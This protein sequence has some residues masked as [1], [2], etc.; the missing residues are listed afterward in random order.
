MSI[1]ATAAPH[2]M[3]RVRGLH[4]RLHLLILAAL[5]PLLII[6]IIAIW[7]AAHESRGN[8]EQ[9]LQETA[10]ALSRGVDQG[11]EDNINQL[12]LLSLLVQQ[13]TEPTAQLQRWAQDNPEIELIGDDDPAASTLPA[14]LLQE[15]R[16]TGKVQVSN[17]FT[18]SNG[19]APEVAIVLPYRDTDGRNRILAMVQPS[20]R[21]ITTV[22]RSGGDQSLLVAVVDANGV[23]AARSRTPER[24]IGKPVPDWE[25]LQQAGGPSG[26][27]GASTKEGH[28]VVF[29]Y[30]MLQ[31]APGWALVIG[32]PQQTF[33]ARWQRPL[34]GIILGG[35]V[36][37]VIALFSANAI[38]RGILQPIRAL[39]QRGQRIADSD[40]TL[41]ELPDLP[42][43]DIR[44]VRSLQD[45]LDNTVQA[46]RRSA[47]EARA[48]A[49]DLRASKQRYRA[50]AEAGA[51]VLWESD[52]HG[53]LRSATGWRELTG[54]DDDTA[55]DQGWQDR[56]HRDDLAQIEMAQQRS[57][58]HAAPLDVEF[59]VLDLQGQWRW[60]RARG[61]PIADTND[62]WAGVLE[63][64]DARRKAQAH[65][66]YLAQHDPLTGL[67]NRT[68]LR[69]K[70][71]HALAAAHR[72]HPSALLLLDLDRFKEV[73]DTLGHPTG[74]RL[75]QE[76]AQRL[77][78]TV[79]DNDMVSRLGGD[80]FAIVMASENPM[81][82]AAATLAQRLVIALSQPF[83]LDGHQF[84]IATSIGIV[85][86]DAQAEAADT[87]M[88]NADLALYRAKDEGRA[89]YRFFETEMDTRMQRRRQ[90]E[91]ELRSALQHQQFELHYQPL[92]D[93]QLRCV[94]GFEALLRWNH[95]Q[96]G[97]LK[98]GEFLALAETLGLM[99][100]LG[101]WVLQQALSDAQAW[102]GTLKVA[103][104]L[105]VSQ[106]AQPDLA[107]NVEHALATAGLPAAR[108]ELEITENAMITNIHAASAQ[109]QRLQTAG[110]SIV[111]DDF[112]S[113]YSSLGYLQAFPFD[114]IKIDKSFVDDLGKQK[115]GSAIIGAVSH[116]CAKLDITATVEGVET[117]AQLAQLQ[118]QDC[119]EGQGFVFGRPMPAASVGD[120][121]REWTARA[122]TGN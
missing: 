60:L 121:I 32:E 100:P 2:S 74:D 82:E 89:C 9:R 30:R 77:R 110:V 57:V 69:D 8:S 56:V 71:G 106:L 34:L 50:V 97:L 83:D 107:D 67:P 101:Q 70:L 45:N 87:L 118:A 116:L 102:P 84:A 63:D 112:G 41:P 90:L 4:S 111:M 59:K 104:N 79:R 40:T 22:L 35:I 15:A 25:T 33:Q 46:L 95:P 47:D 44:E 68:L 36:A 119:T 114:K 98:P 21:L 86:I 10:G 88:R 78:G 115:L 27:F 80:E 96:R 103:V 64:V 85:L 62:H 11:I 122:S 91:T 18:R 43:S 76:V 55:L 37:A 92:V 20:H 73:N 65:I 108:L 5:L 113:G 26:L 109:L 81:P 72:G 7:L 13:A 58:L 31:A 14:P 19:H 117:E 99:V 94:T 16:S 3:V 38:A 29:A 54:Q 93:L 39:A 49:R 28:K 42:A 51:L 23:I 1:N 61:A 120:F 17:L 12:R 53:T 6:G 105:S 24:Y 66:T 75:L 52:G 48:L